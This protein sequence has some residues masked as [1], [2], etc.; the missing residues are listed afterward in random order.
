MAMAQSDYESFLRVQHAAAQGDA[1]AASNLGILYARGDGVLRDLHEAVRWWFAA[2][3]QGNTRAAFFL[4]QALHQ[5]EGAAKDAEQSERW[6]RFAAERGEVAAQ[7]D[8]GILYLVDR[9]VEA[10]SWLRLAAEQG[11]PG[12]AFRLATLLCDGSQALQD[13]D[14]AARWFHRAAEQDD[15]PNLRANWLWELAQMHNQGI[16]QPRCQ[17]EAVR[18]AGLAADQGHPKAQQFVK[19]WASEF[20]TGSNPE[21][22]PHRLV[23][24]ERAFQRA[25]Q[26]GDAN[27]SAPVELEDRWLMAVFAASRELYAPAQLQ[28]GRL[29]RQGHRFVMM[30]SDEEAA[31]WFRRAGIGKMAKAQVALAECYEAGRG[32]VQ[33][34]EE[35]ARWYGYAATEVHPDAE[36][37]YVVGGFYLFR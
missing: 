6:Y 36:A 2:A 10:A 14:E 8:L 27:K 35:A 1:N 9:P 5:G 31:Q 12:A 25:E 23:E 37:Q 20:R 7:R 30:Q 29:Y 32:V 3:E 11:S 28:I 24:A 16:G 26:E 13:H 34:D 33:S 17:S 21:H 18:L 4:A 22:A 19:R 15:D